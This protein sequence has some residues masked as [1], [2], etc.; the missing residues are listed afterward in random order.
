MDR[1]KHT[2]WPRIGNAR[3]LENSTRSRWCRN[4]A[5]F[6]T[7]GVRAGTCILQSWKDLISSSCPR[8]PRE[9]TVIFEFHARD[10]LPNWSF[11]NYNIY[12]STCY[13]E[14]NRNTRQIILPGLLAL[15]IKAK[16]LVSMAWVLRL[17]FVV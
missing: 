2:A 11:L 4:T 10:V 12:S 8:S 6:W 17:Y 14:N 16:K 1:G 5:K 3:D 9:I 13:K 15:Y 7:N